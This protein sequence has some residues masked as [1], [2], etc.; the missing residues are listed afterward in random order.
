MIRKLATALSTGVCLAAIATPALAQSHG[1]DIAAGSLKS[2]LNAYGRESHRQII[3]RSGEIGGKQSGGATGLL[4][5]DDA[6][7][8]IL[9]RTG[10]SYRRDASGALAIVPFV[11]APD[12]TIPP[13][14]G[15][16]ASV[17]GEA[18]RTGEIVVTAQKRTERVRDVPLAV[19][20]ITGEVLARSQ[21]TTLQD[22]VNKTPGVQLVST[23]PITNEVVIRGIS[24]GAHINSAVATYVDEV[25]Y[26]S[27]GPFAYSSNIAPNFD[28]YDL[29]RVEILRGPQGTLYGA[30]ALGG[31]LKYVTNAP[32]TTRFGASI[33]AGVNAVDHGGNGYELRGMVNIP[34]SDTLA[35]RLV[36]NDTRYPGYID[37]PLRDKK[38]VNVIT[39]YGGRAALLW[40]P[41][42]NFSLKLTAAYQR[43]KADDYSSEDVAPGSLKPLFGDLTQERYFPQPQKV[44]NQ[45]YNATVHWDLG[46]AD[47]VSSSSY[48]KTTP[49]LQSDYSLEGYTSG[50]GPNYGLLEIDDTPVHSFIQEV[51][52]SSTGHPLE[53]TIGGYFDD[54]KST[55]VETYLATDLTTG[56]VLPDFVPNLGAFNIRASYREV[57]GFGSLV[58]HLTPKLEIGGGGRYSTNHQ[59]YHQENDGD[60]T[61]TAD[62][63]TR[64]N[65]GVFTYEGHAKYSFGP[66]AV[67]YARIAS[68][69]VPGG[70][71]DVLP[72][73]PVP[74]TFKS[75]TTTNY[76]VGLKGDIRHGLLSYDVDVFDIEW[77]KIQLFAVIGDFYAI[78]NGGGARSRGV[79]GNVSLAPLT[80]L[81][82]DVNGAYTD[83]KL[84][85]ATPVSF[86]GLPGDRLP[87]SP[88]FASNVSADYEHPISMG[89]TGFAGLD[90]RYNGNRL[91]S[92]QY[93]G[94]RQKLPSYSLVDL[95]AGLKFKGYTLTAYVKNVGDTRA[96]SQTSAESLNGV[97]AIS[98]SIL[99][100]RTIGMNL[101][102][103]F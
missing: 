75:S 79:E 57:A 103:K 31:L 82:F 4:T 92:F 81:S 6:L 29:Q 33:L 73:T 55:V 35:I 66:A 74:S 62:I 14:P 102:A 84:T 87:L 46:F 85:D 68:G 13:E 61:G 45:I 8:A 65:Q 54:Q 17:D 48:T 70:P 38:D 47:L 50:Y 42:P 77:K 83:A 78:T 76:E 12:R 101:A 89:V 15:D 25:P 28:T 72:G 1:Y 5:D 90:W 98:A 2:A 9:A 11:D 71:N 53:W 88:R 69:F 58:Y 100:P 91:S 7:T 64:S 27:S 3:Y 20:V 43:L 59:F 52:L 22:V 41:A 56:K 16:L 93:G 67:A 97:D 21:S 26:T 23:T 37:N 24:V 51:R 99:T 44:S 86:G 96:I 19:G 18:T 32:D 80:G 36:G 94:G 34:L 40:K 49:L 39:R 95:R 60:F 30:N 63:T 10:M